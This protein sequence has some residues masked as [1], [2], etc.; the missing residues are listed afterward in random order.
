MMKSQQ[1]I[2]DEILK[3]GATKRLE[4]LNRERE[5]LVS[6]LGENVKKSKAI[7]K[8]SNRLRGRSYNGTHW[9]QR[10]ENRSKVMKMVR[11]MQRGKNG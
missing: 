3:I 6:I 5:Y 1:E 2:K 8:T 11:K 4:E 7:I 9:M 10:P